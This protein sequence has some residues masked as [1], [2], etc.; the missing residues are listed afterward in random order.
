MRNEPVRREMIRWRYDQVP[1]IS[2]TFKF[3]D[4]RVVANK[5][6]ALWVCFLRDGVHG[7]WLSPFSLQNRI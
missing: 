4:E 1:L 2:K 7:R 3:R 5:S 6:D